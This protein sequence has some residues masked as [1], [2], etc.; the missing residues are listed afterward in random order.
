VLAA[1]GLAGLVALLPPLAEG[2]SSRGQRAL[3][4][5]AVSVA[6][7]TRR[8]PDAGTTA[9]FAIVLLAVTGASGGLR[10]ALA[11]FASPVPYFLLGVLAMGA[12]VARSGLAERLARRIL[13]H[14][15]GRPG[16]LYAQLVLAM[17]VLTF[18]LPSATTRTGILVHVY[19][20]ALGLARVAPGP[21]LARAVMLA[22]TSINRLAS[23][24][25]L[26]G[27]I[28]PVM[29]AA[30]IGGL[31]WSRWLV[32]MAVPYYALLMLGAL[33][34]WGL[35]R[36]GLPATLSG[37]PPA[38]RAPLSGA[39]WRTL[40][41]VLGASV[42]WLTDGLHHLDPTLPALLALVA[43]LLPGLGVLQW[44]SLDRDVGWSSFVVVAAS[45]SLAQALVDSGGAGWMASRLIAGLPG[46]AARPFGTI[47]LLM[48]GATGLRVLV[49]NITGFLALALPVAMS[50]GSQSGLNPLVCALVVMMTG[51]AVL[52]FPVQSVSALV[53]HERG[54]VTAG[55]IL[56]FGL[57]MTL[58]AYAAIVLVAL[59][60]WSAVG[61]PVVQS[62]RP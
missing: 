56:R 49:P 37:V 50:V 7:W 17:P 35:E 18:V 42:L 39:Q 10:A 46:V 12:A 31:S 14:A 27:G 62:H 57:W 51:D 13:R 16:R 15:G 24:A 33:L 9:F 38:E 54:H 61:E 22:L 58:V 21:G 32:L 6:L 20:E 40:V 53:V 1:A 28:T 55:E 3:A 2:L 11:G 43:L 8:T 44:G 47:V 23:T 36:R 59:P 48:I 26:T 60:W 25:L 5:A 30:L 41:V 34:I 52:Y 4:V 19:E 45:I 29:S